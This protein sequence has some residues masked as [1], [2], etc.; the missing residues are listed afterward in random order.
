LTD[1]KPVNPAGS[2]P[3]ENV[4]RQGRDRVILH[5]AVE[6]RWLEYTSPVRTVTAMELEEVRPAVREIDRA[7]N[8]QGY[9]AAGFI[10][11]DASPAF[12][13]ALPSR[14]NPDFPLLWFGL[15]P[16]PAVIDLPRPAESPAPSW[17][18][19]VSREEYD[20][21]IAAVKERIRRGDTY[22]VN[23]TYR[24]RSSFAEDPWNFFLRLQEAQNAL[25]GAYVE[26]GEW[27][28]CSASPEQFFT[29]RDSRITSRPMKGTAAR[30]MT[31]RQDREQ[32]EWLYNSEK[33]R[34][35]N[36]MI[37]DM[38]RND[39]GRI[40][41]TGSVR[42][43]ELFALEK[44]PTVWQMTT[45]VEADTHASLP[46]LLDNL[47]P[48]ASITGAPKYRTMEIIKEVENTPRGLYTGSIGF[49]AP[50][51]K[52]QFNVAIRTAVINRR[53]GLAEYGTGGGIVWDSTAKEEFE[54]T[55]TKA[56]VLTRRS[57]DFSL[58]ESLR[59]TP[60]GG[61]YLLDRHLARM[62]ASAEYFGIPFD[63]AQ[64]AALLARTAAGSPEDFG[65]L[66][67]IRL[68]LDRTGGLTCE[69]AAPS[70]PGEW[71]VTLAPRP[72]SS[73]DR[74]LYHK[75][76]HRQVYNEMKALCP[77]F[78]D[79]LLWN[80]K[81]EVTEPCV[82]NVVVVLEGVPCTPPVSC[83][84]LGG[85]CREELLARGELTERVVRVEE[86]YKAD[87][88]Y[89]INSVREA[90]RITLT[91]PPRGNSASSGESS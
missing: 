11:Y 82:A 1:G 2:P 47:F 25:Y 36:R 77:G 17:S 64:A 54:E 68:L 76:T 27:A 66:L 83:G 88:V 71:K 30:G 55:L 58:L 65:R 81:G 52:A 70:Y 91:L 57:P 80:E 5:D 37:V 28:V 19:L 15:Y 14:R 87:E 60:D 75:T 18:P 51:R 69:Y 45:Q 10:S 6:K 32:A 24:L 49:I 86:L 20:R 50:G 12:D 29:L 42:V 22:Q 21:G 33:N 46:E 4:N 89:L 63:P 56:K 59:W 84:L 78:D 8:D 40:A 90:Q 85:T 74:F 39:L 3:G 73:A 13:E 61:Y 23:Y 72:V 31:A 35:E 79:V 26:T 9:H 67:K 7:V 38:I 48:C 62:A 43:P 53:T 44:Y 34:A 16:P 41:E